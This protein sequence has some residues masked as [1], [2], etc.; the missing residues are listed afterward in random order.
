M[1]YEQGLRF[2]T[3]HLEGDHYFKTGQPGDNLQRAR[4]QFA[5]LRSMEL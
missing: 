2:P 4:A 5:L 3:D 1:T